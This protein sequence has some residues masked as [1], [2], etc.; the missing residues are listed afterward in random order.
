MKNDVSIVEGIWNLPT[1]LLEYNLATLT[2]QNKPPFE[3]VLVN[4]NPN[5]A[6][7]AEVETVCAKYKVRMIKAPMAKFNLSRIFNI[8]IR[9]S[10]GEYC[11]MT[12]IDQMF[13]ANFMEELYKNIAPNVVVGTWRGELNPGF[14]LGD[15]DTI[16]DRW[17]GIQAQA[18][19]L[20]KFPGG[21]VICVQRAWLEKVHGYDEVR[22]PYNYLDADLTMRMKQDGLS[23]PVVI[24]WTVSHVLHVT[25]PYNPDL[26]YGCGGT[27]PTGGLPIVRNPNEWGEP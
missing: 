10:L 16:I 15:P 9:A 6:L 27:W 18:V 21:S 20:P 13:E 12:S 26:Y 5:P 11:M 14:D 17:D 24:D 23:Y 4:A 2:R 7:F 8:G 19:P 22:T 3:I 25:H 1:K